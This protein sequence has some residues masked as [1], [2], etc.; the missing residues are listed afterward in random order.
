LVLLVLQG[1]FV[2]ALRRVRSSG[3]RGGGWQIS[4]LTEL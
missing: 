2:G 1:N 3:S 4:T